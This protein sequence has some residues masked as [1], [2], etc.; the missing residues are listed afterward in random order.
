MHLSE[1]LRFGTG[2]AELRSEKIEPSAGGGACF[3]GATGREWQGDGVRHC[4][5]LI[6]G[7]VGVHVAHASRAGFP[8]Y[9][10]QGLAVLGNAIRPRYPGFALGLHSWGCSAA[11]GQAKGGGTARGI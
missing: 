4:G 3:R 2:E 11:M 8:C 10:A 7:A 9:V 6:A 5:N 1:A